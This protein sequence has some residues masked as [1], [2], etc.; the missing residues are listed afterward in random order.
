VSTGASPVRLD[1]AQP[2]FVWAHR[3]AS[4]LAPEN[5]LEAFLL[6]AELGADGVEL[7]V[8]LTRDGVPVLVHDHWLWTDGRR[9]YCR[10]TPELA[11]SLRKLTIAELDWHEVEHMPVVHRG[12]ESAAVARLETV[13]EALPDWLWVDIEIKAGR[14]YDP[15]IAGVV[16]DRIQAPRPRVLV[17][18]FDHVLLHEF[19]RLAPSVPLLAICHA[20]VVSPA[21]AFG[22]VPATMVSVDRPFL[23]REDVVKWREQGFEVSMGALQDPDDILE[24]LDWPLS[25]IFID[26]PRLARRPQPA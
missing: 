4:D 14:D 26:D 6:A 7:D 16:L 24:V 10:P 9:L 8:R 19:G 23:S 12:G 5:S 21:Q 25:S 1:D 2:P 18:S 20:R 3:G 22:G 13:L 17:S 11:R 15:R